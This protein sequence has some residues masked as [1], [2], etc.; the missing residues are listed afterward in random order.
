MDA[1]LI[2]FESMLAAKSAANWAFG[3]MLATIA[4]SVIAIVTLFYAAKALNTWRK[5]EELKLKSEFKLAIIELTYTVEAMPDN[6]SH[7]HVNTARSILRITKDPAAHVPDQLKILYLK[8][9]MV[10]AHRRALKSWL[11]CDQFFKKSKIEDRWEKFDKRYHQYAMKGG[12]KSDVLP[13]LKS[14]V[15]EIVIF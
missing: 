8:E 14:L 1:D 2:S 7:V 6:W 13:A 11:M 12:N 9:D 3:S 15:S 5:Q 10:S 4:S